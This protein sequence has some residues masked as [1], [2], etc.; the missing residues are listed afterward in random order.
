MMSWVADVTNLS[1][2]SVVLWKG[3]KMTISR[4][5][6]AKDDIDLSTLR[7]DLD[8][9][10]K[11]SEWYIRNNGDFYL[12]TD[13][14]TGTGSTDEE[15][16]TWSV[17]S[18]TQTKM[19]SIKAP[20][21]ESTSNFDKIAISWSYNDEN[22]KTI[23]VNGVN[24]VINEEE[25]TF[26]IKE[27]LLE[28]KEND[29]VYKSYDWGN[30]LLDKSVQTVYYAAA[31]TPTRTFEVQNFS[32]D[33]SKFTFIKPTSNPYTTTEDL[34]TIQ[35]YVPPWIV[36]RITVNGFQLGSL[37]PYGSYWRY[38]ANA[39]FG[40]LKEWLNVYKV[41]Y[42][43]REWEVLHTN[44]FTIVKEKPP[45]EETPAPIE[46]TSSTGSTDA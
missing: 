37:T 26:E 31:S 40:N 10:F 32:L 6:A 27:F 17:A 14:S 33:A 13:E 30:K 12:N 9:Y 20:A 41:I 25:K 3:Q 38:H 18:S 46:E 21:D 19:L 5:D 2:R 8:D 43:G 24:A 45:V 4:T 34:V 22:I 23:S 16:S 7:N 36:S 15:T 1:G 28:G 44:A 29:L 35:W 39:E 11:S 42:F